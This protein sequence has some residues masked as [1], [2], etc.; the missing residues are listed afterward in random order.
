MLDEFNILE[1]L[2]LRAVRE[3]KRLCN[4]RR[5]LL[6]TTSEIRLRLGY[7]SSLLASGERIPLFVNLD[8]KE[9]QEAVRLITGGSLYSAR[10]SIKNGYIS[11]NGGIRVGICG[12]AR[13]EGGELIGASDISSLVYRIPLGNERI[14]FDFE[15]AYSEIKRGILI[16]SPPGVGKTSALRA[17]AK[18]ISTGRNSKNVVVVDERC[19]FII[20]DYFASNVDILRG[21]KKPEGM[22]IAL[23]ALSPDVI[24]VDEIGSAEEAEKILSFLYCGVKI[25]ATAH[26]SSLHELSSR[27]ALSPLFEASVFDGFLGIEKLGGNRLYTFTPIDG[28]NKS[29][30]DILKEGGE[31][32]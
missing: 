3:I 21:Y 25:I 4:S 8:L 2:P 24:M 11:I 13:Y 15:R 27:R 9:L 19:E 22:E 17:F 26:A 16:F 29:I 28:F 18:S 10:E 12:N 5:E 6:K 30:R 7:A 20:S 14:D 23:R 1:Y 31:A 32:C